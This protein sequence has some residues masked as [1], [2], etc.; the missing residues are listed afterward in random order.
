MKWFWFHDDVNSEHSQFDSIFC[1]F[2]RL[3]QNPAARIFFGQLTNRNRNAQTK[4]YL[5]IPYGPDV[6]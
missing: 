5:F 2:I 3:D 4:I 6:I 1:G